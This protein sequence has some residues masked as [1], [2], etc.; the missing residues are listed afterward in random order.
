MDAILGIAFE[1]ST[2]SV[3]LSLFSQLESIKISRRAI[4]QGTIC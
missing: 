3:F 2:K 1:S 4:S